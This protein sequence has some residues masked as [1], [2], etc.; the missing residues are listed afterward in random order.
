MDLHA[1]L[2][3]RYENMPRSFHFRFRMGIGNFP[4]DCRGAG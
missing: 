1:L 3:I 4:A 2:R